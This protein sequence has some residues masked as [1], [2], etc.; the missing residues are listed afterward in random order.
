MKCVCGRRYTRQSD[1]TRHEK[2]CETVRKRTRKAQRAF[3]KRRLLG[4]VRHVFGKRPQKNSELDGSAS[5]GGPSHDIPSQTGSTQYDNGIMDMPATA[6]S[7]MI[8]SFV[9]FLIFLTVYVIFSFVTSCLL[10]T[11]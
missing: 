7:T 10:T 2:S 5:H 4:G 8:H 6:V 1:L 9:F 3:D 11:F